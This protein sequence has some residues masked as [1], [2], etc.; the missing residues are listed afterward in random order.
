MRL[1]NI[2][3]RLVW[4]PVSIILAAAIAMAI[5]LMNN[6]P[7][8]VFVP[9]SQT[10]ELEPDRV[11]LTYRIIRRRACDAVVT[12]SIIDP[13]GRLDHLMPMAY[14]ADQ[15]SDLQQVQR[16][17]ISLVLPRPARIIPGTYRM[18]ATVRYSCNF[19]QEIWPIKVAFVVPYRLVAE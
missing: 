14:T 18:Q 7:P 4:V 12:R 1:V 13:A 16:D 3:D 2:L 5:M 11:V 6:D 15:V 8:G 10:V 19:A 17:R 9:G